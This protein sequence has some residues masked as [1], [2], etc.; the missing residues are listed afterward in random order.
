MC[1]E[2]VHNM[3]YTEVQLDDPVENSL[4]YSNWKNYYVSSSGSIGEVSDGSMW[5]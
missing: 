2:V 5:C 4:Y 1:F 3:D